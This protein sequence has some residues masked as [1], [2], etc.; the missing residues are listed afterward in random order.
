MGVPQRF[1]V[2]T[3]TTPSSKPHKGRNENN[4]IYNENIDLIDR[5]KNDF[6][7]IILYTRIY[8]GSYNVL[9]STNLPKCCFTILYY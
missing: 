6:N 9:A 2:R 8:T 5:N 7:Y 3:Y 4:N 1:C